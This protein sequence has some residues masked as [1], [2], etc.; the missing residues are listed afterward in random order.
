MAGK[1]VVGALRVTLGLD[2]AQFQTG[3]KNAQTGLQR[4]GAMART[5]ALAVTTAMVTAGGAI[6]LAMKKLIGEADNMSKMAQSIGI[7]IDQLSKLNYAAD[8]SGVSLDKLGV[9]VKRLSMGLLDMAQGGTSGAAKAMQALGISA[10]DAEGKIRP[11]TAVMEDLADRF[12]K[13]PDGAQKTALAM[14]VFG[15]SGADLI[16][17]LNSGADGLRAMYDEAEQ[18]GIVLDEQTGKAAE[19]FNDN[20]TRLGKVKDGIITQIT[21]AML[22]ALLSMSEAMVGAANNASAMKTVGEALAWTLRALIS[23]AAYVGSAFIGVASDIGAAYDAASRFVRGDFKGGAAAWN[24]GISRTQ[25]L[26]KGTEN[27]VRTLWS[28]PS[29]APPAITRTTESTEA[30]G[31]ST[32]RA[33]RATRGL[34]DEQKAAEKAARDLAN[35]AGRIFDQTRTPGEKFAQDLTELNAVMK[36]GLI[37]AVTYTRALRQLIDTLQEANRRR[38]DD[39][40]IDPLAEKLKNR[41]VEDDRRQQQLA[42]DAAEAAKDYERYMRAAT[43]D[44]IAGGLYAA[45]DGDLGKYLAARLKANLIDGLAKSLTDMLSQRSGGSGGGLAGMVGR[46][47]GGLPGFASGGTFKVGGSPGTD[48]NVVAFRATKGEMVDIRRPGQASEGGGYQM[49]VNPSPYFDLQVQ[50]VAAPLAVGAAA[51]G[52]QVARQAIPA[53]LGRRASYRLRNS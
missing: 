33:A 45:A 20:L 31:R 4:F 41:R 3:L 52:V 40:P 51:Q 29:G 25:V 9:G 11:T 37:D 24:A 32:N 12:S 15:K 18:L 34:T 23:A 43:Y 14:Q 17:M 39:M 47:F 36:A 19:A 26:L 42:E 53:E 48:K 21:A 1:S 35:A 2:S 10:K 8:L 22:P 46:F 44:G 28:P 7:P 5:A 27:F 38:L 50:K 16:P 13:M 49:T 6:G 30:L